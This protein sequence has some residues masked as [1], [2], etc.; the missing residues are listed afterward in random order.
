[1]DEQ[2]GR[3]L[4]ALRELDREKDTIVVLWSDHGFLL[5][6]HSI[7]GKHCL[8]EN[9]LRSPL[10]IRYP[11]IR[12]PG[13]TSHAT[14]ETV[15]L[16]PTLADL[17]HLPTPSDLDGK[18]LRPQLEDPIAPSFKD[19]H[20]FWSG[21]QR[22]VRT[23]RWRLIVQPTKDVSTPQVELFDMQSVVDEKKNVASEHPATVTEL[24]A[25]INRLPNPNKK[26]K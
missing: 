4:L 3:V 24:L 5:G 7:W 18:S 26:P 12:Q 25:K 6:E 22:T 2:V 15:D 19:A 20:G 13:K 9:A 14:V 1:M 10:M 17:C 16:L 23:D 11:G 8:Y 21:G